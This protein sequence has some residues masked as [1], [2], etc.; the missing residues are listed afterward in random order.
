VAKTN[1][2]IHGLV[3][4]EPTLALIRELGGGTVL[5]V[6]SANVGVRGYGLTEPIW[7]LTV[8]DRSFDNYGQAD[9]RPPEGCRFVLGDAREMPFADREFDVVV[10]LDLL[11]HVPPVDRARVLA[12]LGRVASRRVI[13]GCPAGAPA[14]EVDRRLPALYRRF[15]LPVPEWLHEHFDNGFPEPGEL[16]DGLERFGRVRLLGNESAR[17]HLLLMHLHVGLHWLPPFQLFVR[18]LGGTLRPGAGGRGLASWVLWRLRG[19][20]RQPNYR[21]IAVTDVAR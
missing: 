5:E 15:N 14:L 21:T 8:L 2:T 4:Y 7:S 16:S 18:V 13:V 11:E 19:R 9:G 10:A 17:A 20:D 12:E 1:L 3:R 6:G